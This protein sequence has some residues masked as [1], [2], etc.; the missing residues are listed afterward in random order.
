[1]TKYFYIVLIMLLTAN[2]FAQV[3]SLAQSHWI[4]AQP[5]EPTGTVVF[6][7]IFTTKA[8]LR[9]TKLYL[10]AHGI[11][12]AHL[13]G[14]RIG[15]AYFAPGYTSYDQRLQ[16]QVYA[17]HPKPGQNRLEVTLA[18][19]WYSGI[20]GGQMQAA[21][22]GKDISLLCRLELTY[23]NGQKQTIL[24]DSTWQVGEGPI[25]TTGFYSGECQDTDLSNH[26]WKPV[27]VTQFSKGNLVPTVTPPV[28]A[29][30][31]FTPKRIWTTPK[32]EQVLDFG[33]NLAGIVEVRVKGKAGDTI[34]IEHAEILD[35]SGNFYT[36][37]LREAKA[38]DT[39]ILNGKQQTLRP[40]FTYHGF[41]YIRV[42]GFTA[43]QANVCAIALHSNLKHTGTFQCS[44]QL[45]NQL[46][47]NINWSLNS[48][49]VDIPTDCPQR[50]E[51]LGW[52]GDAQVFCA[53]AS[54]NRDV[55]SFYSKWLA[56]L[57]ADQGT[58][59]GLPN[60]IPDVYGHAHRGPKN[61]AAGWGD[62]A[63]IVPWTLYERYGDRSILKQQYA[64]M[65][66][67]VTHLHDLTRNDLSYIGGYGDWYAPGDSTSIPYID[68]CF[69]LHSLDLLTTTAQLLHQ[70]ADA[71]VFTD[72]QQKAKT[73]FIHTYL[74]TEQP[75]THTQTA[76][77]LALQFN[78]LPDSLR[79]KAA[80]QLVALVRAKGNH[81]ATGF[82]GTPYLL[83]VLTATGYTGVAY[84][85][86]MQRSCPSWLY[87]IIKGATTIW[88]KWD[89]IQPD[90]SLQETSFN[91]YVYGAV[92]QWLYETVAGIKL[93]A[94][95]YQKV[96]IAPQPGGGLTWCK[97][98]YRSAYGTI[99]SGWKIKG[100]QFQLEVS[101]P[102][103]TTAQ[104]QLPDGQTRSINSGRHH[105]TC[106]YLKQP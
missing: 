105:F 47:H 7:E 101:I 12:E 103:R 23:E 10:T 20:F 55:K 68:Q 71:V 88:E 77:V 85:L 58:N 45:I 90:G 17:I 34:R 14:Q 16:Y 49:F 97:A 84:K 19:G 64:S 66:A 104:I 60:I 24:S 29:Q 95:G 94:P 39:Y 106:K 1:M 40:H 31:H 82:L 3:P 59:G 62:A 41:R 86:L 89:A 38:T 99:C 22:Y 30:E 33:Q 72:W 93:L 54:F 44:N 81:L 65:K 79:P 61:G 2:T 9:S 70:K 5:T 73:A 37:N 91:H 57:A 18:G 56:D 28:T 87:P 15:Q 4:S 46:Q 76:C 43:T 25:R 6:T 78:L 50:S 48:N 83:P 51:R 67:W 98:S 75:A 21:N 11:Y 63:V 102:Q 52:T 35:A 8:N 74:A 27:K 26:N 36:A 32:G 69:Y 100:Q 42:S 80:A 13:N 92:G 96:L 53:T